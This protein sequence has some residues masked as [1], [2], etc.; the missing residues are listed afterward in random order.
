VRLAKLIEQGRQEI[1]R[2][3]REWE[4]TAKVVEEQQAEVRE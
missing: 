4:D 1:A 3:M 2:V